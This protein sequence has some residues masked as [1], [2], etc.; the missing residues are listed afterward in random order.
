MPA[1]DW[2]YDEDEDEDE[3]EG[4]DEGED[5]EVKP[6]TSKKKSQI[7]NLDKGISPEYKSFWKIMSYPYHL[8]S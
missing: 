6:S 1:L 5:E 8:K 2:H 3:D 7:F 4:E